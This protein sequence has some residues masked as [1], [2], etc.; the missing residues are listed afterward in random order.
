MPNLLQDYPPWIAAEYR[1]A[2]R[3]LQLA[4]FWTAQA[5]FDEAMRCQGAEEHIN[6]HLR[7]AMRFVYSNPVKAIEA[8]KA[9]RDAM[10]EQAA[11]IVEDDY[12]RLALSEEQP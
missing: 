10:D 9:A 3:E 12:I 6:P 4:D 7:K 8:L 5:R 11:W 1:S 2:A